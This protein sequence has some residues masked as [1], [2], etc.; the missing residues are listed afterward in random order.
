MPALKTALPRYQKHRASGQAVV[1]LYGRDF[2]LG[3]HRTEASRAEYDRLIGEWIAA[4]RPARPPAQHSDLTIVE[5]SVK[6]RKHAREYYRKNGR[7]TAT[8]NGVHR[9]TELL[10]GRYGR[11]VAVDFGPLAFQAF[12]SDLI[13]RGLARRTVNQFASTVRR[14][15]RWAVTQ[16]LVPALP[17]GLLLVPYLAWV[18]FAAVLNFAIWRLNG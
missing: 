9:A 18:S 15:F 11:T 2:Y 12:Q 17:A 6:Y 13:A 1:S 10:C 8:V 7:P 14:M 4:G 3:P 16:E 5:A